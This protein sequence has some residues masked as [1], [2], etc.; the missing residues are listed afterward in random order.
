LVAL[1]LFAF[2]KGT[3]LDEVFVSML[4]I[5]ALGFDGLLNAS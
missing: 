4:V 5:L 1:L 2:D 3:T